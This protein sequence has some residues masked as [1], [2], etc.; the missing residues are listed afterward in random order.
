MV[1]RFLIDPIMMI[2]QLSSIPTIIHNTIPFVTMSV[3]IDVQMFGSIRLTMFV[4][5]IEEMGIYVVTVSDI[6][7]MTVHVLGT[8]MII[9]HVR[10][11][12]LLLSLGQ[13]FA[14]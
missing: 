7:S 1:G 6:R 13:V 4:M 5:F 3:I 2:I 12:I 8:Q 9:V 10:G 11:I 14:H